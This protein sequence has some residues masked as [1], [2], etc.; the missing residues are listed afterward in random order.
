[1]GQ[2][3]V[4]NYIHIEFSAKYRQPLIDQHVEAELHA[5]LG[6]ICNGR[7]CTV[8]KV[9]GYMD[10]IRKGMMPY[11]RGMTPFQGWDASSHDIRIGRCQILRGLH[12]LRAWVASS[13]E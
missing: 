10:H 13:L 7:E 5:Y 9:G 11:P 12:P 1:M 6:G 4:K 8:I 3:L 2:S